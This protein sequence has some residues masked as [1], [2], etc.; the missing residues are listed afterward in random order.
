[1]SKTFAIPGIVLF[2]SV[3]ACGGSDPVGPSSGNDAEFYPLAVGNT[4]IY[5][6]T[7]SISSGGVQV[8]TVSGE[9]E[10][11]ITGTAS[12][13]E[14]FD[15]FV[16]ERTITDTTVIFGQTIITDSTFTDYVRASDSGFYGYRHLTD[17]D[18]SYTVPFP[19]Q[20]GATWTF[21]D[22]P[23]TTGEILSMS[24]SVTVEAGSFIDC[25]EMLTIWFDSSGTT[26]SNTSDF[27]RNVGQVRNV[28]LLSDTSMTATITNS[29]VTYSLN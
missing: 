17:T 29:L 23:P 2:L 18:S 11:E 25:M 19:L 6:R 5:D 26:L 27:A 16:Q 28:Y 8:G 7:G 13:S 10:V 21:A 1:M 14:G 9:A 3:L 15:V 4:W 20:D 22:E 12:H 24:A